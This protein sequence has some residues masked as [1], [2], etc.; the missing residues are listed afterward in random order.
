MARRVQRPEASDL[1]DMPA[2][3]EGAHILIIESPYYQAIC[4]EL[5]AGAIA[6]LEAAGATY[7]RIVVPGALPTAVF[8]TSLTMRSL[9]RR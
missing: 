9:R 2:G 8:A 7:E 1:P 4:A 5:A 6:E 3:G